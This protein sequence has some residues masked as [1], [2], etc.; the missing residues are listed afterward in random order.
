MLE[1]VEKLLAAGFTAAEIRQLT[2]LTGLT[3]AQA[4]EP[5][6]PM[7]PEPEAP[8]DPESE[9][10]RPEPKPEPSMDAVLAKIDKLTG[11]ITTLLNRSTGTRTPDKTETVD[12]ILEKV[13][14]GKEE[15]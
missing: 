8:T 6:V 15:K 7:D 1:T 5:E 14:F 9:A 4:P 2:G 3:S 10:P 13:F 12:E 11:S